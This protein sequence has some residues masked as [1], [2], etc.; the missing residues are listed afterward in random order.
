MKPNYSRIILGENVLPGRDCPLW[1]A[2]LDWAMM[3]LHCGM[4]RTV[5]Q[6]RDLC[7]QSGLKLVKYWAPPGEGDGIIE[8][9]LQGDD[10]GVIEE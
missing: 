7:E 8:A 1:K 5:S 3:T 10:E 2:E 9:V 4:A 6:F